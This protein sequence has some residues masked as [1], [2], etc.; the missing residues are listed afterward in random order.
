MDDVSGGR[1]RPRRGDIGV[2]RVVRPR[3]HPVPAALRRAGRRAVPRLVRDRREAVPRGAQRHGAQVRD[4]RPLDR[5]PSRVPLGEADQRRDA[6]GRGVC[7]RRL[8]TPADARV[9]LRSRRPRRR[10]VPL[11]PAERSRADERGRPRHPPGPVEDPRPPFASDLPARSPSTARPRGVPLP[12]DPHPHRGRT[13][14][15]PARAAAL[16]LL[17]LAGCA[18]HA[19]A[20][21]AEIAWQPWSAETFARAKAENRLLLVDVVA[22]WCH[23]CHVM[24]RTTYA[25]ADVAAAISSDYVAV[26]VDHDARPDVAARYREW[27]W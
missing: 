15:K 9:H 22:E 21:S 16:V 14:V 24:D 17:V 27:G 12:R 11:R 4:R 25:D 5:R 19:P 2:A 6:P 23:W 18:T 3:R 20:P 26:R 13:R 8:R 10:A 7:R 1:A